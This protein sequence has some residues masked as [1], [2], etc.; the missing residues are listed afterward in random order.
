VSN[1]CL[2]HLRKTSV[3]KERALIAKDSE[4]GEYD[5]LDQVADERAGANPERDLMQREL[6]SRMA[7]ALE[8]LTPRERMVFELKHYHGLKLRTIGEILQ[9]SEE[10]AKSTLSKATQRF[11]QSLSPRGA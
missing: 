5:L 4:G 10:T 1:I 8:K 6:R 11:L 9:T 7:S 2:D 3:R